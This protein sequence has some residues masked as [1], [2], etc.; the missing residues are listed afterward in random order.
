[1]PNLI[2]KLEGQKA[3]RIAIFATFATFGIA[4]VI[5]NAFN[6]EDQDRTQ[7][8]QG[9]KITEATNAVQGALNFLVTSKGQVLNEA[10]RRKQVLDALRAEYI[11]SHSDVSS[12][13]IAGNSYPP[14]DWTNGRLRELGEKWTITQPSQALGGSVPIEKARYEVSFWPSTLTQWPIHTMSLPQVNGVVTFSFTFQIKDHMAK[15]TRIWLRLC[16]GCRYA[17]EPPGF[18]NLSPHPGEGDEP[19]ERTLVVGDFLPNIAYTP[20]TI[21]VVPPTNTKAF[22]VGVLVGCENCDPID[23]DKPQVLRVEIQP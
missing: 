6:R 10:D 16:K 12:S 21:D 11:M 23:A 5:L 8:E 7:R 20:I 2:R 9:E 4:T 15:Q 1:M 18:Q 3:I 17:K 22:L 13:M 14:P 19:T